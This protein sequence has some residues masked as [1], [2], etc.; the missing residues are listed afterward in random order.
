MAAQ[1]RLAPRG[2]IF[3]VPLEKSL[4][5]AVVYA[6]H[7]VSVSFGMRAS[8]LYVFSRFCERSDSNS[9]PR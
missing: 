6:Y 1:E 8:N 5:H 7:K 4:T 9:D 3:V 2:P